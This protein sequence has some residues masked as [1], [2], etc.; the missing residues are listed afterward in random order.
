M[1]PIILKNKPM[2][3]N[4]HLLHQ[5]IQVINVPILQLDFNIEGENMIKISKFKCVFFFWMV[6]VNGLY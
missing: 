1:I 2:K 5:N 3:D 6:T 4:G